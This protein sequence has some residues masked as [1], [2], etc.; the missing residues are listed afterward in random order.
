MPFRTRL[1]LTPT[2]LVR[3]HRL[4]GGPFM[5][6][7]F[8]ASPQ[9]GS[10]NHGS[11]AKRNAPARSW[12][13]AYGQERT[14]TSPQSLPNAPKMTLGGRLICSRYRAKDGELPAGFC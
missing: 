11:P 8:V 14:S 5:V 9:F 6:G 10:L 1:S 13:G 2:R 12:Y 3:Q 7:E 4:D